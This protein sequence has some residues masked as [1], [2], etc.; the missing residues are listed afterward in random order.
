MIHPTA[1][2]H[3]KAEIGA[4]ARIGP[5]AVIDEHVRVGPECEIGPYV[6]LTGHTTLGKGNKI[7]A[8]AVIG[9]LPQDVRFRGDLTGVVIGDDNVIR[10]HVTIHRSNKVEEPTRLGRGN[11]LMAQVHVGHN[12]SIGDDVI[13][14]NAALIAGHCQIGD[15][16]F[17]SGTCLIHQFT[18]VGM[19]ALMQGG[20]GVSKDLP[21]FTISSGNNSVHGLNVIGL[22]RAGFTSKERL[23]LRR[24]YQAVFR[25][26]KRFRD[27]L[28][29]LEQEFTSEKARIFLDFLKSCRKGFC[30][31]R[32][33]ARRGAGGAEEEPA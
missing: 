7:H 1:V 9:D 11:F 25:S 32:R 2:I 27:L 33:G 31:E 18:R 14:A 19:L 15:R 6:Y 22:R 12:S 5:C 30:L 3:P 10:E 8:G 23:E 29:E 21:P 13:I 24:L 17:I 20:S 16:A 4:G 26:G 28:P